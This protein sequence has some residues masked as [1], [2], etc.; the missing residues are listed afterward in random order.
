MKTRLAFL[1]LFLS[2]TLA[3]QE[4][5]SKWYGDLDM[6]GMK[7]GLVFEIDTLDATAALSVPAQGLKGLAADDILL[8]ADS[9]AL[10]FKSLQ[11]SYRGRFT[12]DTHIKGEFNQRGIKLPLELNR[13]AA[14]APPRRIQTP[15]PPFPYTRR[16]ISFL[17]P[18]AGI[19]LKGT[20][21]LPQ[22]KGPFPAVIL[23]SGSGPQDRHATIAE[24]PWFTVLSDH[25]LRAGIAVLQYDE[26]GI[27]ESEGNFK[28]ANT[29]DLAS[30]AKAALNWLRTQPET[31]PGKTGIIGHSEGGIIASIIASED[32]D[33]PF[34]ILLAS[35]SVTGKELMLTQKLQLELAAGVPES[36]ATTSNLLFK[37]IYDDITSSEL[38]GNELK[39]H[40]KQQFKSY[41]GDAIPGEQ[42]EIVASQLSSPWM[43]A[44]LRIDP[45]PYLSE[46][47]SRVLAIYG[48]KDL[49]V[50]A[51]MNSTSL[52][53][54][55]SEAVLE[56][57]TVITLDGL[58]HLLQPAKTGLPTEYSHIETTIDPEALHLISSWIKSY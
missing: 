7:L 19:T 13:G 43:K 18:E 8:K 54:A 5:A 1:S 14:P 24:H 49:Q 27:G 25:L 35:P 2:L 29:I 47:H 41:T 45:K 56:A 20:Y 46:L 51:D 53:E 40:I 10:T 21:S 15:Q 30:D 26:R 38:H 33:L 28:A 4:P 32:S 6:N 55:L 9:I 58:N 52:K 50:D 17:N 36:A 42:L 16:A 31:Q 48:S 44:F 39:N 37:K 57:S 12:T 3:A 11:I 23:V 22:D 34:I